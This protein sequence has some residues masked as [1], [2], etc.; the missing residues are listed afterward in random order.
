MPSFRQILTGVTQAWND[1]R[2]NVVGSAGEV[3]EQLQALSG[4]GLERQPL[5]A[6][7]FERALRAGPAFDPT[8]AA[9]ATRPSSRSR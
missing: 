5:D 4:V 6:E 8:G 3:A 9:S 7:I 1:D 2:E